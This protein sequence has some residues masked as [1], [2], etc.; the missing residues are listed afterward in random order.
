MNTTTY[1]RKIDTILRMLRD[2]G[3]KDD[4]ITVQV[5]TVADRDWYYIIAERDAD[6]LAHRRVTT[7]VL[8]GRNGGRIGRSRYDSFGSHYEY[9]G[10]NGIR[11]IAGW[12]F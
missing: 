6:N 8:M 5:G 2:G 7:S 10:W 1:P 3:W 11:R 12:G 9:T 4:E